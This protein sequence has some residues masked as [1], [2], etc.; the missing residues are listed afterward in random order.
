MNLKFMSKM[1]GK[2]SQYL[3]KSFLPNQLIVKALIIGLLSTVSIPVSVLPTIALT[4][5][6]VPE[7][8][9]RLL[10]WKAQGLGNTSSVLQYARDGKGVQASFPQ[11]SFCYGTYNFC[12]VAKQVDTKDITEQLLGRWQANDPVSKQEFTFIFAPEGELFMVLPTPEGS[13]VALKVDY[14]I[15]PATQPMQLDIQLSADQEA[16]TIF[17]ITAD[18]KLRLELDELEPGLPRPTEFRNQA[19]FFEKTSELT[20]VP[21]DIQVITLVDLN[22][23]ISGTPEEETKKYMYALTQVQQ[24]HYSQQGKFATA[25]EQ[26]S[27]GLRTETE[28]YRYQFL[29]QGDG[30]K[31]VIIT[32]VAKDSELPSYAGAVFVIEAKEG[33]TTL[34]QICKT[35]QPSRQPPIMLSVPKDNSSEIR[36]P[37][38]SSLVQF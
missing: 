1:I 21:E 33:N 8:D 20:T 4:V 9:H 32:A 3:L 6:V 30:T 15:N 38:G 19:I 35:D 25:I 29:P 14:Q 17:E 22:R 13:S 18:G 26:V 16:L 24:A 37:V 28:S 5:I 2:L 36:C 11:V 34:T 7:A 10:P 31:S 27:I 12:L 23:Q